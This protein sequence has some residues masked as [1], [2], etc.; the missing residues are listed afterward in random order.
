MS[1][2]KLKLGMVFS[3]HR[4]LTEVVKEYNIKLG[5]E[6]KFPK[7]ES[8]KLMDVCCKK[9]CPWYLYGLKMQHSSSIQIKTF[10]D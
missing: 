6:V 2:P 5:K 8:A 10:N 7:N 3:D 1:S 4:E 9:G